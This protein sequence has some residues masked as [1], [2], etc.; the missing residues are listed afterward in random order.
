LEGWVALITGGDSG[1][2]RAVAVL[3]AHEGADIAIVYL[4]EHEDARETVAQVVEQGRQCMMFAGDLT[5]ESLCQ[6]VDGKTIPRFGHQD[7]L[8]NNAAEQQPC[9]NLPQITLQQ[10]NRTFRTHI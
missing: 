5:E 6:D 2:G 8:I 1:I 7:V 4:N 10:W 3:F 9:E